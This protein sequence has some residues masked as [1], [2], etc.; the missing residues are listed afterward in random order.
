MTFFWDPNFAPPKLQRNI[1]HAYRRDTAQIVGRDAF[2]RGTAAL[3]V[4]LTPVKLSQ[5]RSSTDTFHTQKSSV[6]LVFEGTQISTSITTNIHSEIYK[7]KF[8][9]QERFDAT[10]RGSILVNRV[11]KYGSRP[12]ASQCRGIKRE[13]PESSRRDSMDRSR[14]SAKHH[15]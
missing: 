12:G 10:R 14:S 9:F 13:R 2:R 1:V 7:N 5:T 15:R 4:S 6:K 8:G 3:A 11:K